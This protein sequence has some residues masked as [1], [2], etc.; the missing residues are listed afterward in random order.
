MRVYKL[1]PSISTSNLLAKRPLKP[2]AL[3][4]HLLESIRPTSMPGANRSA[5]GML[6]APE[7]LISSSLMT[8]TAA[9]ESCKGCTFFATEVIF[10]A[11]SSSRFRSVRSV[12]ACRLSGSQASNA[13]AIRNK[14]RDLFMAG[15]AGKT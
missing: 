13:V 5:S 12:S 2:R 15:R 8:N 3:T 11:S 6:V 1:L 7:R 10:T 14:E 4:A 9:A